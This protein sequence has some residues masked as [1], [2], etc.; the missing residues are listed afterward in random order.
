MLEIIL[1]Q[2]K[3]LVLGLSTEDYDGIWVKL[4]SR[5]EVPLELQKDDLEETFGSHLI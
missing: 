5:T 4:A 2:A 1:A 3:R